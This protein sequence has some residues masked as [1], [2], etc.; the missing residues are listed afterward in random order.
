[1]RFV[2]I[3]TSTTF[4]HSIIFLIIVLNNIN[5]FINN[6]TGK[7]V[8]M[9][10]IFKYI[11][12]LFLESGFTGA[13]IILL[14]S[15]AVGYFLLYPIGEATLIYYLDNDK[16]DSRGSFLKGLNKFF[17]MF[18]FIAMNGMGFNLLSFG[19]ITMRIYTAGVLDN[20]FVI[21]ILGIWLT[22][23]L[24]LTFLRPYTKFIIVLENMEVMP[25]IG[26][27]IELT[28]KNISMTVKFVIIGLLL[29]LRFIINTAIIVLV[30]IG[31]IFVATSLD[32]IDKT[33]FN[34]IIYG[35]TLLLFLITAY[36]NG[37]IEAFFITYRYKLYKKIS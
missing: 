2:R 28:T 11:N 10:T 12:S 14:I 16:K 6:T 33:I 34:P 27:S 37:I 5:F 9:G 7:G 26:R 15:L 4:L 36:I 17:L 21:T 23:I 24:F 3:T 35:T 18:E 8:E 32:I 20:P 31:M 13:F 1:D 25:A 19:F 29:Q 30:P 22:I